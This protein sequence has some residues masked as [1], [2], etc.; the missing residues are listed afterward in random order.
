MLYVPESILD[1]ARK[2]SPDVIIRQFGKVN[3]GEGRLKDI[4]ESSKKP[5]I[6]ILPGKPEQ[7]RH[8]K[9]NYL[10]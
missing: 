9:Q 6:A 4:S 3:I 8:D 1:A 10:L 2:L 7:E 5:T